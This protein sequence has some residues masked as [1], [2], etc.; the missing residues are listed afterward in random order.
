MR[1][2]DMKQDT[3]EKSQVVQNDDNHYSEP[4]V[5]SVIMIIHIS[6]QS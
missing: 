3:Y 2:S 6:T 4:L 5:N 1:N